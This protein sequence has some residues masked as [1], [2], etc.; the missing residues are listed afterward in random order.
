M[1]D[2]PKRPPFDSAYKNAGGIPN[3]SRAFDILTIRQGMQAAGVNASSIAKKHPLYVHTD[4][5]VPGVTGDAEVILA[6]WQL[7]QSS[8]PEKGLKKWPNGRPVVYHIHGGGQIAGDR[9]FGPEFVMSHFTTQENV[10]FASPE[11][12]L[13]PEHRAPAGAYDV[14]AGIVYLG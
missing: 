4:T 10:V 14:Y 9:F 12:R 5:T 3:P 7:P 1:A 13:A 6:L 11:Y 2:Y 8:Q